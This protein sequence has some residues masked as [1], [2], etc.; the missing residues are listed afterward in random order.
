VAQDSD[1]HRHRCLLRVRRQRPCNRRAA[2]QSDE[3]ASFHLIE[4]LSV[5]ASGE[6]RDNNG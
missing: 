4:V 2:E 5:A 1:D 3:V 6:V